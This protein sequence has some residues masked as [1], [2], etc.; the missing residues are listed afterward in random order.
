MLIV[1]LIGIAIIRASLHI[2][3]RLAVDV[4][5]FDDDRQ[6]GNG[7]VCLVLHVVD[8]M[9]Q[10]LDPLLRLVIDLLN[11]ANAIAQGM[12]A[13]NIQLLKSRTQNLKFALQRNYPV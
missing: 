9:D 5:A 7:L 6:S 11:E 2:S 13:V 3:D 4:L 12:R 10:V 8:A 1:V